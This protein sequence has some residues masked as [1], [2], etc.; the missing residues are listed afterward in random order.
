MHMEKNFFD[1]I[2]DTVMNVNDKINDNEN[3]RKNLPLYCGRIDLELKPQGNGRLLKLKT[4]YNLSKDEARIVCRWM[5]GL[6]M[7]NGYYSNFARC[8][9]I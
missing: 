7:P 6:R 3:A 8:A 9:N 2:F 4:N 1:N 5:K